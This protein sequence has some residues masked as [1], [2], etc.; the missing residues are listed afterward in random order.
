V[1]QGSSSMLVVMAAYLGVLR[2][3]SLVW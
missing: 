3:V 1:W 2:A